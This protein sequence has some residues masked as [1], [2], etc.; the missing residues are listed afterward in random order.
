[1]DSFRSIAKDAYRI[2]ENELEY[3]ADRIGLEAYVAMSLAYNNFIEV[4]QECPFFY[5]LFSEDSLELLLRYYNVIS[6]FV[7]E[8]EDDDVLVLSISY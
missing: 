7:N 8:M 4:Q 1:M 5:S 3:K 2:Y 6:N